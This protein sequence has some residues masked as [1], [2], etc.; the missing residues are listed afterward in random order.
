MKAFILSDSHVVV[1][2]AACID[3]HGRHM[4][5]DED[6]MVMEDRQTLFLLLYELTSLSM[7]L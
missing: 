7:A 5:T 6:Q 3:S 2:V 4:A 1:M